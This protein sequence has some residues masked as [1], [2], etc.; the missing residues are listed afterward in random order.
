MLDPGQQLL[1][2]EPRIDV[3]LAVHESSID[4][5]LKCLIRHVDDV[6]STCFDIVLSPLG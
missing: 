4:A 6:S 2:S 1:G 3:E 5:F